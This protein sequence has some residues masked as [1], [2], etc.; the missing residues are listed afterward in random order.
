MTV[1]VRHCRF[2]GYCFLVSL[3]FVGCTSSTSVTMQ[4][5]VTVSEPLEP[6]GVMWLGSR[7]AAVLNSEHYQ[8]VSD[9]LEA[10]FSEAGFSTTDQKDEADH[11]AYLW[12]GKRR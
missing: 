6:Q 3:A 4:Q 8:P 5:S 1:L 12:F 9:V 2:A 11:Q 7:S 10:A